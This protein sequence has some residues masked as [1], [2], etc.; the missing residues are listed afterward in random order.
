MGNVHCLKCGLEGSS[1]CPHC[2]TVFPENG[3]VTILEYGIQIGDKDVSTRPL[4]PEEFTKF[5]R[6]LAKLS[7]D[8]MKMI[9][10]NHRFEF[11]PGG[12]SSIDCGHSNLL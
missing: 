3:I 7:D 6:S 1:K 4:P 10:C 9:C 2:R 5:I 12:K 8:E 11:K